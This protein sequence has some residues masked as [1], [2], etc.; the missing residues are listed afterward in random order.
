MAVGVVLVRIGANVD[1]TPVCVPEKQI[2][3]VFVFAGNVPVVRRADFRFEFV[4]PV[5]LVILRD[6]CSNVPLGRF[7]G[8]SDAPVQFPETLVERDEF[9]HV[10][11]GPA[12]FLV[13]F[14][15]AVLQEFGMDSDFKVIPFESAFGHFLFPFLD[16]AALATVIE[17]AVEIPKDVPLRCTRK[18]PCHIG[19][20]F[21]FFCNIRYCLKI[22]NDCDKYCRVLGYAVHARKSRERQ[23]DG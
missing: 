12:E 9:F 8:A 3:D 5:P 1:G 23:A 20:P 14:F 18:I 2:A 21:G 7:E 19:P 13:Q 11:I 10:R 22:G 6:E 16:T 4:F 15:V 17:V